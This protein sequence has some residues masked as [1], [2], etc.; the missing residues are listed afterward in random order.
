[1]L[2]QIDV[3]AEHPELLHPVPSPHR[4]PKDAPAYHTV[5]TDKS[6]PPNAHLVWLV[7][8]APAPSLL[9][10]GHVL[11]EYEFDTQAVAQMDHR[12]HWQRSDKQ[13]HTH[14]TYPVVKEP[15]EDFSVTRPQVLER[16]FH[17]LS[18]GEKMLIKHPEKSARELADLT[19][20]Q[21]QFDPRPELELTQDEADKLE[22]L[23]LEEAGAYDPPEEPAPA[24]N[25]LDAASHGR[26]NPHEKVEMGPRDEPQDYEAME[27]QQKT[28]GQQARHSK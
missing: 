23:R 11:A 16:P 3:D 25:P 27:K 6:T 20:T 1:M 21:D 19:D 10:H 24:E 15:I 22:Q 18:E 2:F 14:A 17:E 12:V 7:I 8:N 4:S 26:L 9:Q 13:R 28:K 5:N